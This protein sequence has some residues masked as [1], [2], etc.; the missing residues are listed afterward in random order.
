MNELTGA[1]AC[2]IH[3]SLSVVIAEVHYYPRHS[4][5]DFLRKYTW[6]CYNN[7]D[8]QYWWNLYPI[9][10][11]SNQLAVKIT[12][13]SLSLVC[14]CI[15]SGTCCHYYIWGCMCSTGHFSLGNWKH[16]SIA[17]V[18]ISI[19]LTHC[20]HSFPWLCAWDVC[21][22]IYCHLLHIHSRKI[23]ILFSLL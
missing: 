8:K 19:N 22:I 2:Y 21:Y 20:Y 15:N 11:L 12:R 6:H 18:I 17:H 13:P 7:C 5:Q 23:G 4:Y 16:I 14:I 3:T 1:I 10:I 9:F